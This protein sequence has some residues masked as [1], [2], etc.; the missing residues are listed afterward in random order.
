MGKKYYN[1]YARNR[2]GLG[3]SLEKWQAVVNTVV[4]LRVP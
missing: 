3:S 1:G 2:M 4:I